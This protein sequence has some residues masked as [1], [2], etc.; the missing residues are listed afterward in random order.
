MFW[1]TEQSLD[2]LRKVLH[3]DGAVWTV[4]VQWWNTAVAERDWE[5]DHEEMEEAFWGVVFLHVGNLACE[6][7]SKGTES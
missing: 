7:L 1:Q 6:E 3:L 2:I 4:L 5:V